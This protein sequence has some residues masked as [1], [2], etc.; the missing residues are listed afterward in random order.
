MAYL[1]PT[2]HSKLYRDF[3]SIDGASYRDIIHFFERK[4][5]DIRQLDFEEYFEL[6]YIYVNSL[7]EV[8]AYQKHLVMADEVIEA[9]ICHNIQWYKNEDIF[10]KALFRKAASLYNSSE[11]GHAEYILRELIRIDPEYR[12]AVSFL[13]KCIRAGNIRSLQVFRAAGVFLFLVSAAVICA[14]V[15]LVRPFYTLHAPAVELLR[16]ALFGA[17]CGS[18]VAGE[19][20][21][22]WKAH[23][24]AEFFVE[25]N[26]RQKKRA[27]V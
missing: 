7:F 27:G 19:L 8:G 17:G 20:W 6:L 5:E 21:R 18:L 2:Y 12:D 15:L 1:Q 25:E 26:R 9:A 10:Q 3:K 13:K 24:A 22:R 4:E 14:E 23:R 11:F 16:N